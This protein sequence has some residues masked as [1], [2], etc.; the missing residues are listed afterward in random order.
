MHTQMSN[1]IHSLHWCSLDK[2]FN[3][4]NDMIKQTYQRNRPVS[5]LQAHGRGSTDNNLE[6]LKPPYSLQLK[7]PFNLQCCP[8][9]K[10]TYPTHLFTD[11]IPS[12]SDQCKDGVHVPGIVRGKLLSKNGNFQHLMRN[13]LEQKELDLN[14]WSCLIKRLF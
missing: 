9:K 3:E 12:I 11:I 7:W 2:V 10:T 4:M 5:H 1:Y 14:G 8:S 6:K 13:C